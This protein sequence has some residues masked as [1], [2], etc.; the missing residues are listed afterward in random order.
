MAD[1]EMESWAF[2]VRRRPHQCDLVTLAD[3]VIYRHQVALVITV[4]S[5]VI[6]TVLQDNQVAVATNSVAAVN[7]L[8]GRRCNNRSAT[9][10][11]DLYSLMRRITPGPEFVEYLPLERP[12]KQTLGRLWR[13]F[14]GRCRCFFPLGR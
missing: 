4:D 3:K 5:E 6:I 10:G 2:A 9:S 12:D 13:L 11:S 8:A 1:F 14:S 7:D